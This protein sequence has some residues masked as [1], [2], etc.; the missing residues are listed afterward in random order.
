MTT[1]FVKEY[2]RELEKLIQYGGSRNE[3]AIRGAFDNLLGKYCDSKGLM[4]I[5]ELP[6]ELPNKKTVRPDGTVK[7][8]LRLP[9]GFWESKDKYDTLDEE[10]AKKLKLGYPKS[11]ILFEDSQ[12]AVLIQHGEETMRINM[13]DGEALDRLLNAFLSYERPEVRQFR[14]A[15]Q[16][17]KEDIPEVIEALRVMIDKQ[18]TENPKYR[19]ARD[20]FLQMGK[21]AIYAELSV[22]D[23]REMLIQHILTDELFSTVYHESHFHRDNNVAQQLQ[24]VINTFFKGDV[25]RQLMNRVQ[26]FYGAIREAAGA[27]SNYEEKQKFLKIVY[28]NFYKVYN[29]KAADRLGVVYT[30]NEIVK[31]MVE[32]TDWLLHKHFGKFLEDPGVDILDP[33]TGTGTFITDIMEHISKDKLEYKYLNEIHANEVAILPY[34]IANL[35]IEYTFRQRMGKYLEFPN[36]CFVDT[37]DNMDFTGYGQQHDLFSISLENTERIKKQ[38][39]KKISVVIGNPPYNAKQEFYNLQNANR[40]YPFIDSRI[41]E[42]YVKQGSAQNQIVLYDMYVRFIRWATDRIQENGIVAFVSNSSF[43]NGTAF[44]GFRKVIEKEFSSLYVVNLK[45]DARTA[46][47][48]RRKQGGNIF[49]DQIKVGVAI[50]FLIR[51]EEEK[52]ERIKIYYNE[53]EDYAKADR[54]LDFIAKSRIKDISFQHIIPSQKHNW[55]KLTDNNFDDLL[56]IIDKKVKTGKSE[57]AVFKLFSS[58][59]KTQRDEWVYDFNKDTL[60]KK[61]KYLIEV[62]EKT[63]KNPKFSGK[64]SI[65]WDRELNKYFERNISKTYTT[66]QIIKGAFRPFV[67]QWFYFD[68]HLNA[69]NYQWREI[70]AAQVNTVITFN[71]PGNSKDFFCL[72]TDK[73]ADLH[74]TGDSQCIPLYR[75][76]EKG[77][78]DNITAWGLKQFREHYNDK[79]ITAEDIFHYA[80]A[81]LHNPH[82][83]EK[84]A[85]NLKRD[86]PRLP[87]YEDFGQWAAW[88]KELMDLHINFE[89][90]EPHPL[91]SAIE[92]GESIPNQKLK[93]LLKADKTDGKIF[94]S[95]GKTSIQL[96]GIPQEAWQYKLGNRSAL[97][98]VLD[99]YKPKKPRDKTIAEKFN[100]YDFEEYI[101]DVAELLKK[102][103]TVSLRTVEIVG[104]MGDNI[105][106]N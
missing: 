94:L 64:M 84:Y 42:T 58:G 69:M 15:I 49:S 36:I 80:Y 85:Q 46:G 103:C 81:V 21:Q 65:K 60:E 33:A 11:N 95:S 45:G 4:L 23:V 31:F 93:T 47:E 37:L 67:N 63:R 48:P 102:V 25:R 78:T 92:K 54:K 12:Q 30:P 35:N 17:F 74:F 16:K 5:P 61:V 89:N 3:S 75:K 8:S 6:Y 86:F 96:S 53:I 82:Y 88:G 20:E 68:R 104:E 79:S 98:W 1:Y 56:P 29:P 38:N 32:S 13:R 40:K 71:A 66:D 44:D 19:Q 57:K 26:P 27:I 2:Q 28:E 59:I 34:Y 73:I 43:I 55:I 70:M 77:R 51:R 50:Y 62:Y 87:F 7:D 9:W 72:A 24:V 22:D 10:I 105:K 101:F 90:A 97:E 100:T 91:R 41:K 106:I 14:S 83:R 52:G 18:A 76:L 99:Q 39:R